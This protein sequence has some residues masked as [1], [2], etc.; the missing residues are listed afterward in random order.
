[1]VYIIL[2]LVTL[3][4]GLMSFIDS[5][6][7]KDFDN[8]LIMFISGIVFSVPGVILIH[9][10]LKGKDVSKPQQYEE[11]SNSNVILSRNK[12]R[13]KKM[14]D[15]GIVSII[16]GTVILIVSAIYFLDANHRYN[17]PLFPF[18]NETI[19]SEIT[20]QLFFSTIGLIVGGVLLI[21]GFILV[22][23]FLGND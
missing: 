7:Y 8:F 4:I 22:A 1:M 13:A 11:V 6:T 23:K 16:A 9:A 12:I 19:Q 3:I 20:N 17:N 2:G 14:S 18:A 21:A 5:L 15:Y 10:G